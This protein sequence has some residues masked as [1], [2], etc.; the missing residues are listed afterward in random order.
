MDTQM[1]EQNIEALVEAQARGNTPQGIRVDAGT[2]ESTQL[3]ARVS[4]L[5]V[6]P[7]GFQSVNADVQPTGFPPVNAEVQP[8][9]FGE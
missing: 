1:N 2:V 4:K 7:S 5:A 3:D 9:G 6:Q 8:S